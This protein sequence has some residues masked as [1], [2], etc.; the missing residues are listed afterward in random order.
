MI[1]RQDR[2]G[3][4]SGGKEVFFGPERSLSRAWFDL[5]VTGGTQPQCS[6]AVFVTACPRPRWEKRDE[7]RELVCDSAKAVPLCHEWDSRNEELGPLR[8]LSELNERAETSHCRAHR[9]GSLSCR[10]AW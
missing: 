4:D 2:A 10:P 3:I 5:D 1:L 9:D 7:S 8:P 6:S